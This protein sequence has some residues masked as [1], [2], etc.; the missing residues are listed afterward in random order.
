[1]LSHLL[2]IMIV[3]SQKKELCFRFHISFLLLLKGFPGGSVVNNLPAMQE[4]QKTWV[5]SL[6]REDSPEEG[7]ATH[8]SILT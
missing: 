8:S 5:P 2:I 7:M 1:M 3:S 6:D 4:M